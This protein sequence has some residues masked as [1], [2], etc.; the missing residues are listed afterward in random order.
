M[1]DFIKT[2]ARIVVYMMFAGI[3]FMNYATWTMMHQTYGAAKEMAEAYQTNIKA[4]NDM[5]RSCDVTVQKPKKKPDWV[6]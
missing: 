5:K 1:E 6:F 2:V 4:W 3:L